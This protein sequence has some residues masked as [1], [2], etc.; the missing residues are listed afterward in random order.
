MTDRWHRDD[1]PGWK[2]YRHSVGI[3]GDVLMM[4]PTPEDAAKFVLGE[5]D[6]CDG[7]MALVAPFEGDYCPECDEPDAD[8][9]PPVRSVVRVDGSSGLTEA[10]LSASEVTR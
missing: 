8:K 4:D 2:G 1:N 3:D 6:Y 9:G 10:E 7:C 5:L